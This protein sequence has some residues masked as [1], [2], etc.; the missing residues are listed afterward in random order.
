M[1]KW[2]LPEKILNTTPEA[3][4]E[5]SGVCYSTTHSPD[6]AETW[7]TYSSP[8]GNFEKCWKASYRDS[9]PFRD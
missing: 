4:N 6:L 2:R 9:H 5:A 3:I 8:P 7:L 1:L